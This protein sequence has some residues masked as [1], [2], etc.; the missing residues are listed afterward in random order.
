MT[1]PTPAGLAES[2]LD[3]AAYPG[4]EPD[5]AAYLTRMA[6]LLVD[7]ADDEALAAFAPFTDPDGYVWISELFEPVL[8]LA[9]QEKWSF[10]RWLNAFASTAGSLQ[11]LDRQYL[12]ELADDRRSVERM[13]KAG[14]KPISA[15]PAGIVMIREEPA[16]ND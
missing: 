1:T 16:A 4:E 8:R 3:L 13:A 5:F 14:W 2:L 9:H 15:N 10:L 11:P 12:A 7:R 6:R